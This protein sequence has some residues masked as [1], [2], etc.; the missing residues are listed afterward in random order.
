M[1]DNSVDEQSPPVSTS[2]D[3]AQN[4]P[5]SSTSETSVSKNLAEGLGEFLKTKSDKTQNFHDLLQQGLG[6]AT[7]YIDNRSGGIHVGGD[8]SFAGDASGR[9]IKVNTTVTPNG[10]S[11]KGIAGQVAPVDIKKISSVYIQTDYYTQAQNILTEK[12][13]LI[14]RGDAHLGKWSTAINLLSG[15]HAEGILEI[16]PIIEDLNSFECTAQQGYVIDGFAPESD[17]KLRSWVLNNLSRKF[18]ERNSHLIITIDSSIPIS[19]EDL[20]GYIVHWEHLPSITELLKKHL[21]WYLP[22]EKLTDGY[23]L[24][25]TEEICKLLQQNKLLLGDI[26]RLAKL[27]LEVIKEKLTLTQALS[28]FSLEVDKQVVNWF[29]NNPNLKQRVFMIA[30]AVLSGATYNTVLEA[31]QKLQFIAKPISEEDES[32]KREIELNTKLPDELKAIY[33]HLEKGY[34]NSEYGSRE[35]ELIVFDISQFQP[36][37]LSYVWKVL[38]NW[39]EPLLVWLYQ[40]GSHP[41]FQVRI[42]ATAALGELSKHDFGLVIEKVVRPWAKSETQELQQ[43][44]AICLSICMFEDRLSTPVLKLLKHWSNLGNN[45]SFAQTV[46]AAYS[47]V[48]IVFPGNALNDLLEIAKSGNISIFFAVAQSIVNLFKA[49]QYTA[50]LQSI[51]LWTDEAQSSRIHLLGL[52]VFVELIRTGENTNN[53]NHS[54]PPTLLWLANDA[55]GKKVY[56]EIITELLKRSLNLKVTR[57]HALNGIHKWLDYTDYNDRFYS[58]LGRVIYDLAKD[59][60]KGRDLSEEGKRI[61]SYLKRWSI[62]APPNS[63][64]KILSTISQFL[65][66]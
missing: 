39:R 61:I 22:S 55:E 15:L 32:S 62:T 23:A 36:A 2:T 27:L 59:R 48:G 25:Q 13:I 6:V 47:G 53:F 60:S 10:S 51:K 33:A 50:V 38:Y 3:A 56:P 63:A 24:I 9:D 66:I 42:R 28:R 57:T 58:L 12:H 26:D 41:N 8:A 40:L 52:V 35:V 34:E 16:D 4:K 5:Q 20:D 45:P 54:E 30:L 18:Q 37:I 21:E 65:N 43:L 44:A 1:S 31:S 46:I 19:L 14:I 64:A 29:E 11:A 49:G 7:V 17:L